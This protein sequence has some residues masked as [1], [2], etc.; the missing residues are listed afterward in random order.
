MIYHKVMFI[1]SLILGKY[2]K[3]YVWLVGTSRKRKG[4][5]NE[6][7][8]RLK[9]S[10]K[11]THVADEEG[12]N[13]SVCSSCKLPG[14][15]SARSKACTNY[16]PT[17]A[18]EL[19]VLLGDNASSCTRKIKLETIIRDEYKQAITQKIQTVCEQVR[20]IMLRAQLFV[21]YYIIS[22]S[23]SVVD[24]KVF[25]QNF[26]YAITQLILKKTPNQKFLPSDCLECWNSF[27]SRHNITYKMEPE[28]KGYSHCVS[29]ACITTA[30]T[31]NNNIVE[32][33]ETRTKAFIKYNITKMFEKVCNIYAYI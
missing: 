12:P 13:Q 20:S 22:H 24:K 28:V 5:Q 1:I 2:S 11:Y 26:W 10:A 27:S 14:H 31:Y 32:C 4:K 8:K 23:R 30:T 18:E 21:N 9:K 29:A 15:N 19:R 33:F 3:D 7:T 6:A 25:S 17:K 16:K